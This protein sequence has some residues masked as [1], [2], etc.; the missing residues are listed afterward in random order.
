MTN[1]SMVGNTSVESVVTWSG[2]ELCD[3]M[4]KFTYA[5]SLTMSEAG[6]RR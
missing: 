3:G 5:T 1:M 6:V 2:S 4:L